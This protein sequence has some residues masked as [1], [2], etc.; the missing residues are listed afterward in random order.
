MFF[1][2]WVLVLQRK[3]SGADHKVGLQ[4]ITAW[5][6][7]W[8]NR[9]KTRAGPSAARWRGLKAGEDQ[10][11]GGHSAA[12]TPQLPVFDLLLLVWRLTLTL[13]LTDVD[14]AGLSWWRQAG[15]KFTPE[16][17]NTALS[18]NTNPHHIHLVLL[19]FVLRPPAGRTR[20][21][22]TNTRLLCSA[23]TTP[24]AGG[25]PRG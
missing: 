19:T 6:L 5:A 10:P 3:H 22:E 18:N 20:A 21:A 1:Q 23:L 17:K 4:K 9:N 13:T 8:E 14:S 2:L 11:T 15:A 25:A 12:T 16:F 7:S 24:G